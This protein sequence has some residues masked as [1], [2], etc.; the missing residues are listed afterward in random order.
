MS[1]FIFLGN[2]NLLGINDDINK[3]YID[4]DKYCFIINKRNRNDSA[5]NNT[6]TNVMPF[7]HKCV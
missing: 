2:F 5:D 3:L 4:L 7:A 1:N 6:D